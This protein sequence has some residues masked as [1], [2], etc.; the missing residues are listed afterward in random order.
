MKSLLV[1]L[2]FMALAGFASGQAAAEGALSH[3]LAGGASAT[4]GKAL[5][6]IGNQV[7]GRLGQQTANAVSPRV[8]NVR[9]ASQNFAKKPRPAAIVT[10]HANGGSLI[11]SIEGAEVPVAKNCATQNDKAAE[12]QADCKAQ[13]ANEADAHPSEITLPALK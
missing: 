2:C 4:A 13:V 12:K 3:A 9:P 7:A 8:T 5:G 1:A 6:Q 10:P 11:A